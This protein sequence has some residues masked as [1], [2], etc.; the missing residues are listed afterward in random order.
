MGSVAVGKNRYIDVQ[1]RVFCDLKC[2]GELR[3]LVLNIVDTD[4]NVVEQVVGEQG[5]VLLDRVAGDATTVAEEYR[6]SPDRLP[7]DGVRLQR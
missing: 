6:K 1:S 2:A 3:H 5:K 4:T 7:A